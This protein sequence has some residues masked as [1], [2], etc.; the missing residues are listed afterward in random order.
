MQPHA[1]ETF[2]ASGN[3]VASDWQAATVSTFPDL[4]DTSRSRAM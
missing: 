1:L 4:P 3:P 2:L